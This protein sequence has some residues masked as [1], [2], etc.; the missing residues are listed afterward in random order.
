MSKLKK[1]INSARILQDQ[2]NMNIL[3]CNEI[4]SLAELADN[5]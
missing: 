5:M 4:H 3:L 2:A 1:K